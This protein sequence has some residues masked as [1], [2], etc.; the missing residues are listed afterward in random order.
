[1]I[2]ELFTLRSTYFLLESS[3]LQVFLIPHRKPNFTEV[4]WHNNKKGY[5]FI[6]SRVTYYKMIYSGA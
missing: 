2:P 6:Q 3:A 5:S 1:M 4:I